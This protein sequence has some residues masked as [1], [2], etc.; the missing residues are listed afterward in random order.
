VK[1]RPTVVGIRTLSNGVIMSISVYDAAGALVRTTTR[2]LG[3]NSFSHFAAT[4]LLGG[5]IAANQTVVFSIDAASG[6]IYGSS[7]AN[8]G[9]GS[10]LQVA[11]RRRRRVN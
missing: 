7:V 2:S 10:T 6:V 11:S 9:G 8:N 3:P 4:D 1:V 5:V